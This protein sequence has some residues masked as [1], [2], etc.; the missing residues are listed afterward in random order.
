MSGVAVRQVIPKKGFSGDDLTKLIGGYTL[1][2]VERQNEKSILLCLDGPK[3]RKY[4]EIEF[5]ADETF[6]DNIYME[7]LEEM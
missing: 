2:R 7:V 1:V 5:E 6:G 3:R 4:V